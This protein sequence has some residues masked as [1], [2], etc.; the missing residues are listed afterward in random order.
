VQS[1]MASP[2]RL[3]PAAAS[4]PSKSI[5]HPPGTQ[6]LWQNELYASLILMHVLLVR[7]LVTEL[8]LPA[9]TLLLAMVPQS[10]RALQAALTVHRV[11]VLVP[12]VA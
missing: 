8:V 7:P 12:F 1:A 6:T 5:L 10:L 4:A 11:Q 2:P 3:A 9:M